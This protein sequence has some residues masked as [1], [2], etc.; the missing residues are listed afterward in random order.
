M[1]SVILPVTARVITV[2]SSD[3][4]RAQDAKKQAKTEGL[5]SVQWVYL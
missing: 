4:T 3:S 5:D 1:R 2:W